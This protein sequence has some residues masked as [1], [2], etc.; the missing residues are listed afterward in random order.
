MD[1]KLMTRLAEGADPGKYEIMYYVKGTSARWTVKAFQNQNAARAWAEKQGST[2]HIEWPPA[3]QAPPAPDFQISVAYPENKG[4]WIN[5]VFK[6]QKAAQA[7]AKK[8]DSDVKIE[9]PSGMQAEESKD[10][11]NT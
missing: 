6:N 8:Q 9:W 5:K 3:L 1:H 10:V 7:W 4:G 2:V 11:G